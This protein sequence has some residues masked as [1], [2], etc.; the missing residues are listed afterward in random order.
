MQTH[1]EIGSASWLHPHTSPWLYLLWEVQSAVES[2]LA[3]EG[4]KHAKQILSQFFQRLNDRIIHPRHIE[5]ITH[6][7]LMHKP[8]FQDLLAA[9]LEDILRSAEILSDGGADLQEF[10]LALARYPEVFKKIDLP[11]PTVDVLH[12]RVEYLRTSGQSGSIINMLT[13]FLTRH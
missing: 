8:G 2:I 7:E 11:P 6:N 13:W 12:K 4:V 1:L 5:F 9:R 3:W 10:L